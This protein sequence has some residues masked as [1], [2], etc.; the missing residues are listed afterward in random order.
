M[1]IEITSITIIT[2]LQKSK[3]AIEKE[4]NDKYFAAISPNFQFIQQQTAG[5]IGDLG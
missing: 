4:N 2:I 5:Q 1:I 3:Q